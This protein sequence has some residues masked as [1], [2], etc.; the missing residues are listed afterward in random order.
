MIFNLLILQVNK[1]SNSVAIIYE[2]CLIYAYC[3]ICLILYLYILYILKIVESSIVELNL[4][5]SDR[6][7]INTSIY[8]YLI[9]KN[10]YC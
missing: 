10:T 2:Y 9:L 3:L 1:I 6:S 7:M 5:I 4:L 8:I